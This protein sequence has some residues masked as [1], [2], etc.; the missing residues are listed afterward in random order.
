MNKENKY[1]EG[2]IL[3][4]YRSLR[5][6]ANRTFG[7]KLA[8]DLAQDSILAILEGKN[9]EQRN[10]FSLIDSARR[11]GGSAYSHR[12]G[13]VEPSMPNAKDFNAGII[14]SERHRA[15]FEDTERH[16]ANL[17]TFVFLV[18]MLKRPREI[19]CVILKDTYEFTLLEISHFF[20]V[21]ESRASQIYTAAKERL[22]KVALSQGLSSREQRIEQQESPRVLSQELQVIESLPIETLRDL[23]KIQRAQDARKSELAKRAFFKIPKAVFSFT[24]ENEKENQRKMPRVA[25][26]KLEGKSFICPK[27]AKTTI[28]FWTQKSN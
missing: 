16:R 5:R 14:S 15:N 21:S 25:K 8:E 11:R 22:K 24:R 18:S 13:S 23:E 6:T 3:R 1:N 12:S 7:P 27:M 10:V 17:F 4:K 26:I 9:I 2:Q 20:G 28:N 19:Q